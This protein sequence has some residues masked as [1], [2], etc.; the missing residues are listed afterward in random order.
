MFHVNPVGHQR[1]LPEADSELKH[2]RSADG[3]STEECSL[4]QVFLVEDVV[5]VK[6]GTNER[7]AEC[8]GESRASVEDEAGV[9][10]D[11]PIEIKKTGAV[12]AAT[13]CGID[14]VGETGAVHT[15]K[16]GVRLTE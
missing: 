4:Q 14:A 13:V 5:D 1:S 7:A 9:Y 6:L 16:T 15:R 11:A 10:L 2:A 12:G 8:K 3:R